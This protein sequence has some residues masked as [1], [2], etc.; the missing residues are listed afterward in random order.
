MRAALFIVHIAIVLA[1]TTSVA[2]GGGVVLE[3]YTGERPAD[4]P[5]LLSPVLEELSQRG[6]ASGD[7]VARTYETQAS[8]AAVMPGGMPSDFAARV[9]RGFNAWV[10]GRFDDSIRILVPLVETAQANTGAFAKE[11]SLR[12]PLLK[13][14]IALALAYQRIGDPSAMRA[15]FGEILRSWP[16]TQLPRATYGPDAAQAFE[17]VRRELAATGRGTLTVKTDDAAVVFVNELYRAAGSTTLDLSPGEYRVVVMLNNQPSRN[18]RVTVRANAETTVDVDA[19]FDQAIRTAGYTGLSFANQPG[20]EA[21]EAR[22]AR[23]FANAV[24]A[25]AVAVVGIDDVRGRSAVVG[26]L[27]SLQTGRE[28]RRASIPVEPDPS[29][30][31]LRALARFLAGDDPAPGLDVQFSGGEPDGR[32]GPEAP[33]GETAGG[34]WGGWRFVTAGLALGGIGAGV[35]LSVLDGRCTETPP[36][37]QPCRYFHNF[38]P[39]GY[40]SLAGGTVLAGISIYLFATHDTAP[41]VAPTRGGATVGFATRF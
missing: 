29:R 17:Q 16:G 33:I 31:K 13:G 38:Q 6:F 4:A 26:S 15:A 39:W 12:E 7:T 24:G 9:D 40:V 18:H 2:R 19:R 35:T 1:V 36:V 22:Y 28:L 23:R 25:S 8:R 34:R 10:A 11:P 14:L 41:V 3:S 5:R 32:P 21:H 20:R 27:I 30:D 37:G